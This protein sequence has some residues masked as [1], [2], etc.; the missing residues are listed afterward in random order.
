MS[1][2]HN[3]KNWHH[4]EFDTYPLCPIGSSW[5][6]CKALKK[7]VVHET[8]GTAVLNYKRKGY[9]VPLL[10]EATFVKW[11]T[12]SSAKHKNNKT[13]QLPWGLALLWKRRSCRGGGRGAP[14]TMTAAHQCR[15]MSFASHS[16]PT[17]F[18]QQESDTVKTPK[19]V[20]TFLLLGERTFSF[21]AFTMVWMWNVPS[22][23]TVHP[24]QWHWGGCRTHGAQA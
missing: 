3:G 4:T 16:N 20:S 21:K 11:R 10:P 18:G 14:Q 8:V 23:S 17:A 12:P 13:G 22:V 15:G 24:R 5:P 9:T 19:L 2:S 6:F 7:A 1:Q